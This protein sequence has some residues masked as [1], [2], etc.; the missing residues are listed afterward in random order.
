[1]AELEECGEWRGDGAGNLASWMCARWQ[2]SQRSARELVRDAEALKERPALREA[3]SSGSIS[4]DQCKA[5]TTLSEPET[6]DAEAWLGIGKTSRTISPAMRRAVEERDGGVCTFPG[7][8]RDRF[9][10]CHHITHVAD[11][12]P[13]EL[14]NL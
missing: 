14:W 6:D 12:G 5:L 2:I 8:G 10:E 13:T 3:L 9:L 11:H 7:C 1:M 4:I